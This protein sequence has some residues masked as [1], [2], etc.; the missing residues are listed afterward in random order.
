MTIQIHNRILYGI[1]LGH[2]LTNTEARG[3]VDR[4]P[5]SLLQTHSYETRAQV[6]AYRRTVNKTETK[7]KRCNDRRLETCGQCGWKRWTCIQKWWWLL[8]I[9]VIL[10]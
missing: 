3:H 2:I 9:I 4:Q 5:H 6:H 10:W 8:N 7:K 1:A